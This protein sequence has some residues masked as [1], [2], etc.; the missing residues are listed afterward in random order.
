LYNTHYAL[1]GLQ[2]EAPP[3][4]PGAHNNS[5]QLLICHLADNDK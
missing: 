1:Y 3:L 4:Y 5:E 2:Y